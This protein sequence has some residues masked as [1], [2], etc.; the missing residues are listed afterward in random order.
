M[1]ALFWCVVLVLGGTVMVLRELATLSTFPE[2][3]KGLVDSSLMAWIGLVAIAV[4]GGGL[5]A[6]VIRRRV[7]F[8]RSP[9]PKPIGSAILVDQRQA[10]YLIQNSEA[11]PRSARMVAD[12]EAREHEA[13]RM[14]LLFEQECPKAKVKSF[15]SEVALEAWLARMASRKGGDQ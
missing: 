11:F 2:D 12:E 7:P 9:E 4:G 6:P 13:F 10:M 3:I 15:Y 1:K 14:M 5:L 8:L